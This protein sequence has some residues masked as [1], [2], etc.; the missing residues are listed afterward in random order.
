M[1]QKIFYVV[2]GEFYRSFCE[3]RNPV[4][5][6]RLFKDDNPIFA[7]KAAFLYF[8]DYIDLMLLSKG[9]SYT[10]YR[11]AVVDLQDFFN[12]YSLDDALNDHNSDIFC[13]ISLS[14]VINGKLEIVTSEGIEYYKDEIEIYGMDK[15]SNDF[16]PQLRYFKNLR[17]ERKIYEKRNLSTNAEDIVKYDISSIFEDPNKIEL[18]QTPID[19]NEMI[20]DLVLTDE[21]I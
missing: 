13:E 5:I 10:S 19:F 21:K 1:K 8:Q 6:N 4:K 14:M 9:K 18:L 11:Q 15:N 20:T 12:S 2:R 16:S 7:R 3:K 17:R